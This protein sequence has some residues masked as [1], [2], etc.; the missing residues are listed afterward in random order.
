MKK[1]NCIIL[2]S[3]AALLAACGNGSNPSTS[4]SVPAGESISQTSQDAPKA[5]KL[6][7]AFIS[8]AV[9]SYSN[10]RPTYN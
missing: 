2:L 4:A 10:M 7:H 3:S 5:G 1:L 6:E 8:T 9:M